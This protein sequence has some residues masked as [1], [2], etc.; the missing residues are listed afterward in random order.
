M[1]ERTAAEGDPVLVT[2]VRIQLTRRP[3][4]LAYVSITLWGSL[5]VHDLRILQRHDG[6]RVVLMPRVQGSDGSWSTIAHPV[7]ENVRAEI[8]RKVMNAFAC[9]EA[10]RDETPLRVNGTGEA[11][12]LPKRTESARV[13]EA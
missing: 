5:A 6:S 7:R 8:E 1:E 10:E 13:V 12:P 2:E 4:I 9:A 3:P 11:A